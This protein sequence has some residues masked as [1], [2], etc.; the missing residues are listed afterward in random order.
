L[1]HSKSQQGEYG[2]DLIALAIFYI[3]PEGPGESNHYIEMWPGSNIGQIARA[4]GFTN[5]H[6]LIVNSHGRGLTIRKKFRYAFYPHNSFLQPNQSVPYFSVQ[7]IAILLGPTYTV[8]I[9]NIV[10]AGCNTDGSFSSKE[11][12]KY[13]INATN[14]THALPGEFGYQP[15]L[16][17]A[18]TMQSA[19]I[20]A[21]YGRLRASEAKGLECD[22]ENRPARR[23][24][25]S[26]PYVADL[27]RPGAKMP[28]KTQIAGREILDPPGVP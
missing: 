16:L 5:N 28:F 24:F 6:A 17:Q 7:D 12:R 18:L 15:M 14:I 4:N 13:F 21:L 8:E 26:C 27:Y 23:W 11:V 19:N 3:P 10:V 1:A 2:S 9:H 22:V 25:T 20:E